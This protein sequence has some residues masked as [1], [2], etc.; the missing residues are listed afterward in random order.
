MDKLTK[1]QEKG[2]IVKPGLLAGEETYLVY[3]PS[4]AMKWEPETLIYRSSIWTKDMRPVSLGFKKFF[5]LGEAPHIVKDP[6]DSD[7]ASSEARVMEKVDG[8]CLIVSYFNGEMIV[9]TRG[10]FSALALKNGDELFDLRNRYRKA[11]NNEDLRSE[12]CSYLYEWTTPS[13]RI[14]VDYGESP[15][16]RLIARISH[17]DYSYSSQEELDDLAK[18][19]GVTRPAHFKA[20]SLDDIMQVLK[21]MRGSEGYCIYFNKQQD[22]KKVKCEWYLAAHRFR[23]DCS[24]EYI[25]DIFLSMGCP[26]YDDFIKAMANLFDFEC[27][28]EALKFAEIVCQAYK[29]AC[30]AIAHMKEFV[31]GLDGTSREGRKEAAD[32]IKQAYG[33][34]NRVSYAFTMLDRKELEPEQLRKIII[35][36]MNQN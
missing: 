29:K 17:D 3:P 13:N 19:I 36:C 23:S 5:N 22:I 4:I 25:L 21:N 1:L 9:R 6:T 18:K 8:S 11:F 7:V 24:V 33:A 20:S 16:I 31:G 35:Q 32:M 28:P 30:T 2:F 10:T 14:V 34:M 26:S 12:Q 27:A 15:D